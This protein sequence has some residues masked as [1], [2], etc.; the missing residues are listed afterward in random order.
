MRVSFLTDEGHSY[1]IGSPLHLFQILSIYPVRQEILNR[2]YRPEPMAELKLK[3]L[4]Y[5]CATWKRSLG[6]MM[7]ENIRLKNRIAE[8][9]KD[10]FDTGLLE[11]IETF[12][13][14]FIDEDTRMSLLRDDVADLEKLLQHEP[15][16]TKTTPAVETKLKKIRNNIMEAE[17][18][19][20]GLKLAFN[21]YLSKNM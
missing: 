21:N 11:H 20:S 18:Q 1:P 14:N 8:I 15:F 13:N 3:Q 5:E 2:A 16:E 19:F 7:E 12:Q 17:K 10:N 4:Q 6:F 9:L